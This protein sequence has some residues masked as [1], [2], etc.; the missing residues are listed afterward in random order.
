MHRLS[1][2]AGT[3]LDCSPADTVAAAAAAGFD[4]A[5]IWIDL[6]TWT[7]E[8]TAAVNV[9][10][11]DTGIA[12]LDAEVMIFMPGKSL[13]DAR[14]M[15][16]IAA[17]VG[18]AN[19]LFVSRDPDIARTTQQYAEVCEYGAGVGV[20]P[21]LEFM[22]FMTVRTLD[23]ALGVVRA[24]GHPWGAVLIDALH[25]ARC[26][27]GPDEVAAIDPHLLPY[28]QLCD[29]PALSPP[30]EQLID[31]AVNKRLLPGDGELPLQDLIDCFAPDV[32]F[33]MEM[34]SAALRDGYPDPFE[35]A[36]VVAR[37]S[38]AMLELNQTRS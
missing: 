22:R 25:L 36:A 16:D 17:A 33:S 7:P 27:A 34:R 24:A 12:A 18:A 38:L 23:D 20:R 31:E 2:A 11:A 9:R 10:L 3:V 21:V 1:L 30:A 5:G 4:A 32:P 26:G 35:R 15:L 14:R 28:A 37:S 29:G 6:E 13:D 8:T 19:A